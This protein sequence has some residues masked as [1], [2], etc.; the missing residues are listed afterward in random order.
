MVDIRPLQDRTELRRVFDLI[1]AELAE[2]IDSGD[3]RIRDLDCR[4]PGDR[5]LM[6]VAETE[7]RPVGGALAFRNDDG[8]VALRIMAVLEPFRH[9]GVGR[10]VVERVET[11]ARALGAQGVALGT[12]ESVGFWFHLGYTPNLLFQWVHD[13]ERSEQESESVLGGPLA[14]LPHWRSSYDGVPQLYV[15]LD[16]PRLD[17][18]NTVRQLVDGCHVGFMMHKALVG[19]S[20]GRR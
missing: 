8:W 10:R 15:E 12:D 18:R 4:F 20:R 13:A 1:G 14:G 2:P 5:R 9:R 7:G 17:L 16:E 11:E 3:I 6:V 19:D